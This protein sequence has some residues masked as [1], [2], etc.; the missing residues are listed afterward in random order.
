MNDTS[1]H[2]FHHLNLVTSSLSSFPRTFSYTSSNCFAFCLTNSFE[3]KLWRENMQSYP[4]YWKSLFYAPRFLAVMQSARAC[5]RCPFRILFD[6]S[7]KTIPRTDSCAGNSLDHF[8]LPAPCFTISCNSRVV[9]GMKDKYW[10]CKAHIWH[11]LPSAR[12]I[13]VFSR[14]SQIYYVFTTPSPN[15]LYLKSTQTSLEHSLLPTTEWLF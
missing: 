7:I 13:F 6:C 9:F 5:F 15:A 1:S 2:S 11:G 14:H 8:Y 4:K 3:L 12:N 10:V